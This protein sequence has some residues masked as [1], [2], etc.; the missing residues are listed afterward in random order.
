[1]ASANPDAAY[2]KEL[3]EEAIVAGLTESVK[4]Q[5]EDPVDFMGKFLINYADHVGAQ[6][7]VRGGAGGTRRRGA[8][9][10]RGGR[11]RV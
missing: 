2:L 3:V 8:G 7:K 10:G 5:P 6:T 4:R 9:T 11:P 1:M